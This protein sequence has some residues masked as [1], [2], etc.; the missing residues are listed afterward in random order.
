MSV[1]EFLKREFGTLPELIAL[2][3]AERPDRVALVLDEESVTYA[4]LDAAA[5]RVAAAMQRDGFRPGDFVA[6]SSRTSLPYVFAM[7][8]SLR[9]GVGTALLAPDMTAENL[10][11]MLADS[12]ARQIFLDESVARTLKDTDALQK[13]RVVALDN[14]DNGTRWADWLAPAGARPEPVNVA[15]KDPFNIIYSSG[16]TG[17]PKGIVLP[18]DFR[19]AQFQMFRS[20]GYDPDTVAM[21]SIPLYSNM[22]LSSFLPPLAMGGK[23]VLMAKFDARR[24]LELSEKHRITHAMMVPVQFQRIMDVEDF[25]SFDLSSFKVK[26]CG[27]AHFP[28]ELK[29]R[30]LA[31]WPGELIEFYGMT[32]GGGVCRLDARAFPDK[33]HSVGR[34]L[35]GHD[36]RV[37]DEEGNELPPGSVGEIVGNS[38]TMMVCYHKLPEKTREAEWFDSAGKRFIRTGDVGRF[39]EDGFLVLM[40][41]RKDLIISGGFNVYPSDLEAVLREHPDVADVAV[42]GVPSSKWGE[43]PVA[44]VIARGGSDL[45]EKGLMEWSRERLNKAQRI[46]AVEFVDD[47]PRNGIGKVLKASLKERWETSGRSL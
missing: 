16:T 1:S 18:H 47:L 4:E 40:D 28:A 33:L 24:Y 20:L 44:F 35:D 11:R 15:P 25:G 10:A 26:S 45:T 19:W 39:D 30:I 5:D 37:I 7:I 32:E 41:R 12:D 36:M 9:A 38:P 34:P 29:A 2:H 14:S 13:V 31:H 43:T 3:A 42:A 22:T 21:V 27:S 6:I 46:A 23:I 8:G 17:A